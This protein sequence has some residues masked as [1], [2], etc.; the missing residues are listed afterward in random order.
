[1]LPSNDWLWSLRRL[2]MMSFN[3]KCKS[4]FGVSLPSVGFYSVGGLFSNR[5]PQF[6]LLVKPGDELEC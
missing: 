4:F 2:S 3:K 6:M 1:V 5:T